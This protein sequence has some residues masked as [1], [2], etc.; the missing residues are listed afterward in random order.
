[1]A[2][3]ARAERSVIAVPEKSA[4]TIL[5]LTGKEQ[6]CCGIGWKIHAVQQILKPG[7]SPQRIKKRITRD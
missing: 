4:A 1:M 5:S 3:I 7:I 6:R 2:A